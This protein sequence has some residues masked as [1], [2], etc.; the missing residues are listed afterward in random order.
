MLDRL[1]DEGGGAQD[2]IVDCRPLK[3]DRCNK[4]LRH[5]GFHDEILMG[6]AEHPQ[7]KPI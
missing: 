6:I 1:M 5:I 4:Y 3:S 7:F 2:H